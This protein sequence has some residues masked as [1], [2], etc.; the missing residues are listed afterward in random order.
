MKFG[1]R[2]KTKIVFCDKDYKHNLGDD[3]KVDIILSPEFYWVRKFN[4]P[5][6]NT[7]EA[8][9][10]LPAMFDEYLPEGNYEYY[11][12]K[13]EEN[14]FLSFA[15]E[16]DK[17]LNFIKKAN[18]NISKVN[19]LRFAQTEFLNFNDKNLIFNNKNFVYKNDIL[20]MAPFKID[21]IEDII[22][23]NII[24]KL[25]LTNSKIN[26]KFYN[27]VLDKKTIISFSIMILIIS[28][29]N[30]YKGYEIDLQNDAIQLEKQAMKKDFNLPQTSFQLD[31]I[32]KDLKSENSKQIEVKKTL[33]ELLKYYKV[34]NSAKLEKLALNNK[35][36]QVEFTGSSLRKI[37][38]YYKSK[39]KNIN[40]RFYGKKLI[41]DITYE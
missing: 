41:L 12:I 16:N 1:I 36:I 27:T 20:L 30:F 23:E 8:L 9:K 7:K 11:C 15:Y 17:I 6:K 10:L 22:V 5:A 35:T 28:L 24:E 2:E 40:D 39:Y 26:F 32:L 3:S 33:M 4:L 34:S 18:F 37:S 19:S 25:N 13:I 31:S 14:V 38:N 21:D 29:L